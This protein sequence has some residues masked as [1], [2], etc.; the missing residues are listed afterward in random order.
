MPRKPTIYVKQARAGILE[1]LEENPKS[2][3]LPTLRELGQKFTIH[4]ST[5]FRLLRDLETEG[6]VWQGP[7]GRFF[8]SSA[9]RKTLRRAPVCF[10]GREM[11]Q[12]SQLYQEIL[13]GV[14]EVCSANGSPLIFLSASTLVRVPVILKPPIFAT[15]H[16]Q[17]R[18]LQRLIPSVPRGCAGLLFDHLWSDSALKAVSLPNGEAVQLL[19]G[20]GKNA[21]VLMPNYDAGAEMVAHYVET[22]KFDLLYLVTPFEGDPAISAML[23]RLRSTLAPFEVK[24]IAFQDHK[25]LARIID[26]T[27]GHVGV[28]CPEDNTARGI[29]DL[30]AQSGKSND[31]HLT[32]IIATQGT[33]VVTAP[34][35][36]LRFDYRRLGR[37]AASHILHGTPYKPMRPSFV[38]SLEDD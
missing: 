26:G 14:A 4:P 34:H 6:V 31:Q 10:I 12:W 2:E 17:K 33:G 1:L 23:S 22:R 11:W 38:T 9:R 28:V 16:G 25:T 30:I 8:H 24:E 15:P 36:R 21:E 20:S 35:S 32:E 7:S 3:P 18:E 27:H 19:H 5:I 13:E 37:A 29:A